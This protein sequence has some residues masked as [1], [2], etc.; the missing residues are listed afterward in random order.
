M[1]NTFPIL[2]KNNKVYISSMARTKYT[3]EY[4]ENKNIIKIDPLL[5][6]LTMN[7][8]MTTN[9]KLPFNLWFISWKVLWS[10]NSSLSN[11]TKRDTIMRIKT[12]V[13]KIEEEGEDITIVGHAHIFSIMIKELKKREY[14]GIYKPRFLKNGELREYIK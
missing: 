5:D 1:I 13:D 2:N 3:A 4:L 14:K 9:R 12:F 11:E 6:E 8:F 7:P 10:L